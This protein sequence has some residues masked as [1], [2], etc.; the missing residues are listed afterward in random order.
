MAAVPTPDPCCHPAQA[1]VKKIVPGVRFGF[2]AFKFIRKAQ[3]YTKA[4]RNISKRHRFFFKYIFWAFPQFPTPSP[5]QRSPGPCGNA[6]LTRHLWIR[7][8]E[9]GFPW[10]ASA[11]CIRRP[12]H[13]PEN[14]A[15]EVI[16]PHPVPTRPLFN[17]GWHPA[18]PPSF[19]TPT[20]PDPLVK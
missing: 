7:L 3:R 12:S 17:G 2:P 9:S 11:A 18:R 16:F 6:L 19:P 15:K 13:T 10:R 8:L 5:S 20:Y 1:W 14:S 4:G